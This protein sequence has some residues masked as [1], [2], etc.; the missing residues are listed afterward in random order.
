MNNRKKQKNKE[1][2]QKSQLIAFTPNGWED[3]QYWKQHDSSISQKI[4]DLIKDCLRNPHKGIGK[5]EPLIGDLTGFWSRR[6]T[7]EHR[8]VYAFEDNTLTIIMCRYH[9]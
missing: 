3:Y 8:L 7:Q 6:I 2:V 9:Y 1:Q 4:D 5:P